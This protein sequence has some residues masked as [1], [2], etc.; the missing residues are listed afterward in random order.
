M[1]CY[2]NKNK[3]CEDCK[4]INTEL[5]H[6]SSDYDGEAI[7]KQ[8]QEQIYLSINESEKQAL[9]DMMLEEDGV[10]IGHI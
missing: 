1:C 10:Y 8:K 4:R 6:K 2:Y 5:R 3:T 7:A 9:L